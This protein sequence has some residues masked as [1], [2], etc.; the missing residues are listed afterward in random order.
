MAVTLLE[1]FDQLSKSIC[2]PNKTDRSLGMRIE[3]TAYTH[4]HVYST[5]DHRGYSEP[6]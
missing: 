4:V 5:L 3:L 1:L 2:D 6:H